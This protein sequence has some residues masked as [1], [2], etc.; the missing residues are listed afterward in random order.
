MSESIIYG[1]MKLM[2]GVMTGNAGEQCRGTMIVNE[3]D[4]NVTRKQMDTL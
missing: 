1:K 3:A 4:E 2:I